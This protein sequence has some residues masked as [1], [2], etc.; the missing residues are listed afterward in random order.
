MLWDNVSS[1][2]AIAGTF[3]ESG[4]LEGLNAATIPKHELVAKASYC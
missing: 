3:I 1:R 2:I 4:T